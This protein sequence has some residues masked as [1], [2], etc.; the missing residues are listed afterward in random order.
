MFRL[1]FLFSFFA[2]S[3]FSFE[4]VDAQIARHFER[5]STNSLG[6]LPQLPP[7]IRSRRVGPVDQKVTITDDGVLTIT[8]N[9]MCKTVEGTERLLGSCFKRFYLCDLKPNTTNKRYEINRHVNTM[10]LFDGEGSFSLS[11]QSERDL[12]KAAKILQTL[13]HRSENVQR[14]LCDFSNLAK[15]AGFKYLVVAPRAQ[16]YS[17]AFHLLTFSVQ[18]PC[19]VT[20]LTKCSPDQIK[21][22]LA[23]SRNALPLLIYDI[24][25]LNGLSFFT[26]ATPHL[27]SFSPCTVTGEMEQS[28][29]SDDTSSL[30]HFLENTSFA[31]IRFDQM[32]DFTNPIAIIHQPLDKHKIYRCAK[33]EK[34]HTHDVMWYPTKVVHD[35]DYIPIG[36][37][38]SWIAG[39]HENSDDVLRYCL[40]EEPIS[41]ALLAG[42]LY[43]EFPLLQS[44]L[45]CKGRYR[46]ESSI[47][48]SICVTSNAVSKYSNLSSYQRRIV[49]VALFS[50]E[51]GAAFGS[52]EEMAYNSWPLALCIAE[53][54]GFRESEKIALKTLLESPL[55]C[56]GKNVKFNET[57][58][59]FGDS[60]IAEQ[61]GLSIGE[62]IE[63][64]LCYWKAIACLWKQ[65]PQQA[66]AAIA[67]LEGER[68]RY[69]VLCPFGIS[70]GISVSRGPLPTRSLF[71]SYIWEIRDQKHRDGLSLK[72]RRE[73]YEHMLVENQESSLK[74]R[75]WDW[76]QKDMHS[77]FPNKYLTWSEQDAYRAVFE[78]GRLV[79]P[80]Y[81]Q[82]EEEVELM[83]VIDEWGS[84]YLGVKKEAEGPEAFG[85][86]HASFFA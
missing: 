17:E 59:F 53:K 57:L 70:R 13:V 55:P 11:F 20:W 26:Q 14:S 84:M 8:L 86:N 45:Q 3:L 36:S 77:V 31:G 47:A 76:A 32:P 79:Y 66:A 5:L 78:E 68:H 33:S 30:K 72:R 58:A 42:T 37:V 9:F 39:L 21:P 56:D 54:V 85:M 71:S 49:K 81:P 12:E 65:V 40:F 67:L 50:H 4:N 35:A 23:E 62:W 34:M 10:T 44:L 82:T 22:L 24:S 61:I 46:K 51:M 80:T 60:R 6:V 83:F 41:Q 43:R 19:L 69:S 15:E 38:T 63:M 52:P 29:V 7:E 16:S 1:F 28:I 48:E 18:S 64:K 25:L 27:S 75:F 73:R 74:G 2:S